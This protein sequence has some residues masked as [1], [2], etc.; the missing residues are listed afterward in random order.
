MFATSPGYEDRIHSWWAWNSWKH[1]WCLFQPHNASEVST[2]LTAL[3]GAGDGAGDW[4]IAVRSGGH[5]VATANNIDDGVTID[6]G[7]LN[8]TTYDKKT[9]LASIGP[10]AK[11]WKVYAA[12]QKHDVL[13][14][15]GRDGDVGVGGFTLGGG[16]T[17]YMNKEGFACDS[18][19]NFEVVLANGTIVNANK[20]QNADLW[21]A[22]KGGGSNFGIVTRFDMEALPNK[23]LAYGVKYMSSNHTQEL[24]SIIV[25]FTTRSHEFRDDALV[26]FFTHNATKAS[27]VP[28]MADIAGAVI[29]VNTEGKQN[30]PAFEKLAKIPHNGAAQAADVH[31]KANLTTAAFGSQLQAGFW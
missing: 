24:A 12:L 19:R 7:H 23:E 1:P 26:L 18:V 16:S 10:G 3:L 20:D 29:Y 28:A 17:Y 21:K 30:S 9:N 31:M 5:N 2:G 15:G 13:V 6:L 14:T 27:S 11:W 8:Q 4:H 25:N 22:L